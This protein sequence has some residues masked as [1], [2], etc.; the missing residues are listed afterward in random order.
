MMFEGMAAVRDARSPRDFRGSGFH[1]LRPRLNVAFKLL[2]DG[3]NRADDDESSRGRDDQSKENA[4]EPHQRSIQG[5]W[6]P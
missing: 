3:L 5:C 1:V 2:R 4:P 6:S